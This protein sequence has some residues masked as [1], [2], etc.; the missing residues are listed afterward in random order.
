MTQDT[1]PDTSAADAAAAADKAAKAQAK[2]DAKAAKDAEKA[3]KATASAEAK[4]KKEADKKAKADE[5]AAVKTAKE[6][7]K[8]AKQPEQNG[9]R[10]PAPEGKCGQAW[11]LFDKM[12]ADAGQPIPIG[13]AIKAS[14]AMGLNQANV[15]CEYARWKKFYGIAGRVAALPV[16]AAPAAAA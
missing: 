9:V 8:K 4:A 3:A 14:D 13:D 12:S 5:K 6:S 11:A 2:A 10:R 1:T 15:R 16:A 7:T